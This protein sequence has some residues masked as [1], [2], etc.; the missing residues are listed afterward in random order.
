MTAHRKSAMPQRR[1]GFSLIEILIVLV[2]VSVG[3]VG[4][5]GLQVNAMSYGKT[6]VSRS[7]SAALAYD[8]ADRM[9]SNLN[10]LMA[11]AYLLNQTWSGGS[12]VPALPA[13]YSAATGVTSGNCNA[14]QMAAVD[15]NQWSALLAAQLPGGKARIDALNGVATTANFQF[16]YRIIVG[17]A[18]RNPAGSG[19]NCPTSFTTDSSVQCFQLDVAP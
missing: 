17:Y 5:A 2:V 6:A 1:R 13:C 19:T 11:S 3:L 8:M 10:G 16:G 7:S 18:E 9:R 15:L 14:A 12:A 4:L